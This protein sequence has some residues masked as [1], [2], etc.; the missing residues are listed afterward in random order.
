M[1]VFGICLLVSIGIGSATGHILQIKDKD[2]MSKKKINPATNIANE[3][4]QRKIGIGDKLQVNELLKDTKYN[5][6]Y[7]IMICNI[8]GKIIYKSDNVQQTQVDINNII[9]KVIDSIDNEDWLLNT[10][11]DKNN[12][13]NL[14]PVKFSDGQG[15]L[16]VTGE[17]NRKLMHSNIDN[18]FISLIVGII[19]FLSIFLLLTNKKM[20][21]IEFVLAGLLEISKGNLD[22]KIARQGKD[23]LALLADNINFMAEEL[24]SQIE[25]ERKAERIKGELIT[26]VSHDLR[27]PLTSIKGYLELIKNKKYSE[28]NQLEQYID[29]AYIKAEKLETLVTDLFDYTKIVNNSVK[30]EREN[31]VLNELLD[32]LIEEFVPACEDNNVTMTKDFIKEKVIVSVD[33]NKTVRIFENL[34]VNAISYSLKPSD[35]KIILK[36][37]GDFAVVCISNQCNAIDKEELQRIFERFYRIEK[38][39]SSDTGGSGLGLAI[40]KNLMEIQGGTLEA[41]YEDNYISFIASFKL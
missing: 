10:L 30:L 33:P 15:Y 34:L 7:K 31:I 40:A 38:S 28:E 21:Y 4:S 37:D 22:Y 1:F 41:Q 12:Y 9:K 23:E 27:T 24:K 3:I 25:N 20:K 2:S 17:L 19:S 5:K 13:I 26:N 14:Y 29:I 6:I 35:I 36:R 16:I 11:E 18:K 32:Q 39:R 8:Q